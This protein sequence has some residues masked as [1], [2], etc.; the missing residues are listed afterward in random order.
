[1]I[2]SLCLFLFHSERVDFCG[3]CVPHPSEKK[4]HLRL[5]TNGWLIFLVTLAGLIHPSF[6]EHSFDPVLIDFPFIGEP[7]TDVLREGISN[8]SALCDHVLEVFD[9][10][11][12]EYNASN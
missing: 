9:A 1:M 2:I 3:Y 11:I 5:Q 7:A 10:S 12:A 8:L 6:V 4:I